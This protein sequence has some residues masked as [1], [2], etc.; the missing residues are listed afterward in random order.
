MAALYVVI[1][2]AYLEA[3]V[4]DQFKDIVHR[5]GP[6]TFLFDSGKLAVDIFI[7]LSGYSLMLPVVRAG[8]R[9]KSLS[10]FVRRRSMRILPPYYAAVLLSLALIA[11][12]PGLNHR[13][14][15]HWDSSL[16]A[17]ET[18]PIVSHL[19]MIH[20]LSQG[21]AY[22]INHALWSVATECQIYVLFPL[23][24]LPLWRR[25]GLAAMIVGS[26]CVTVP[27]GYLRPDL[28]AGRLW[29]A[30]L[31]ALGAAGAVVATSSDTGAKHLRTRVP[32]L[33]LAGVSIAAAV[34]LLAARDWVRGNAWI[35][36]LFIG[37]ST[38][39]LIIACAYTPPTGSSVA[40]ELL[41]K[42]FESRVATTLGLFSYSLYLIHPP[43]IAICNQWLS[44]TGLAPVYYLL[45]MVVI[46]T[47]ACVAA[48]GAFYWAIERWCVPPLKPYQ[49][50]NEPVP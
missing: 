32:W 7:V 4:Q 30:G 19:L 14:G 21:W 25:F 20:D 48:G 11:W 27:L 43:I 42:L 1:H 29:Y 24:M 49:Q 46:G 28:T 34:P 6:L 41:R 18:G 45:T 12:V 10:E 33:A 31:F 15:A 26:L 37:I 36:D 16:P 3:A 35:A 17:F 23:L 47:A 5:L 44:T 40:R 8:G 2:H 9:I 50:R 22:R 39:C 38:T 13:T